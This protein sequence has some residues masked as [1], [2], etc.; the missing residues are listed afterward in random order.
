L[1]ARWT[2][3]TNHAHVL[4]VLAADPDTR[5]RDVAERVGITERSAQ[6]IVGDLVEEGYLERS[7]VGRRNHYSVQANLPLRHPLERGHL[8]RELLDALGSEAPAAAGSR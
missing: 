7:R 5:L 4:L 1:A 8:V 6:S 2:F 3:L